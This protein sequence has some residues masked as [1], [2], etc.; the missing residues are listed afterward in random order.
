MRTQILIRITALAL[1]AGFSIPLPSEA[2]NLRMHGTVVSPPVNQ[3]CPQAEDG[4]CAAGV[5][6]GGLYL[7]TGAGQPS[8]GASGSSAFLGL[9]AM[10]GQSFTRDATWNRCAVEYGCGP[11][12]LDSAMTSLAGLPIGSGTIQG[13]SYTKSIISGG[14]PLINVTKTC[15]GGDPYMDLNDV[16]VDDVQLRMTGNGCIVR[17]RNFTL[18][19]GP[20]MAF[21]NVGSLYQ[22]SGTGVRSLEVSNWKNIAGQ[23]MH[24][25]PELWGTP[26]G[27]GAGLTLQA[28]FTGTF[29][30]GN[31]V[32]GG[33]VSIAAGGVQS[34]ETIRWSQYLDWPG[35]VYVSTRAS[36][37][38]LQSEYAQ[39]S[40]KI[41]WAG[42]VNCASST[43]CTVIDTHADSPNPAPISSGVSKFMTYGVLVNSNASRRGNFISSYN[44]GSG[45]FTVSTVPGFGGTTTEVV[46]GEQS[47][48]GTGCDNAK[49]VIGCA[50]YGPTGCASALPAAAASPGGP[51]AMSVGP[52]AT[53]GSHI[54]MGGECGHYKSRFGFSYKMGYDAILTGNCSIDIES[55]YNQTST[56]Q[57]GYVLNGDNSGGVPHVGITVIE[58]QQSGV[59]SFNLSFNQRFNTAVIDKW[60]VMGSMTAAHAFFVQAGST[61]YFTQWDTGVI[62]KNQVI[63]NQTMNNLLFDGSYLTYASLCSG[64]PACDVTPGVLFRTLGQSPIGT[65]AQSAIT[66]TNV[67]DGA[68]GKLHVT[69]V[70]SG[71]VAANDYIFCSAN[72]GSYSEGESLGPIKI[73]SQLATEPGDVST[74]QTE[75]SYGALS[76]AI[77]TR[78]YVGVV[79]DMKYEGNL[80][81]GPLVGSSNPFGLGDGTRTEVYRCAGNLYMTGSQPNY[82]TAA[83]CTP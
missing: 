32:G 52:A 8:T 39:I 53:I 43:T 14:I 65:A 63:A 37:N 31:G 71:A 28:A 19:P 57:I 75:G 58:Q 18:M 15:N 20:L 16:L 80:F 41:Y 56:G 1:A 29:S 48:T 11:N 72:C 7:A 6:A 36:G 78:R 17:S 61:N 40:F 22:M 44:P 68:L 64:N 74:W 70:S 45:T 77:T 51:M 21:A 59:D 55:N 83:G 49:F 25:T 27:S 10:N 2:G 60:N 5:A 23:G 66:A 26:A 73:L 35:R 54:A 79:S 9:A 42:K 47:C 30:A 12:K 81:N 3:N 62:S 38:S 50:Q 69:A 76:G 24:A 4:N 33:W 34:G 46:V 82:I 67:A 13:L